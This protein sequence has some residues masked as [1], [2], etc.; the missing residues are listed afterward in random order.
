MKEFYYQRNGRS[1]GP[2]S[3]NE[4]VNKKLTKGTYIWYDGLDSWVPIESVSFFAK[5]YKIN[6]ES[7]WRVVGKTIALTVIVLLLG[8]VLISQYILSDLRAKNELAQ[9]DTSAEFNMYLEKF[10]RDLKV[11]GI[12][13]VIPNQ[14]IIKFANLDKYKGTAYYNGISYGYKD[15]TK[16]EIHINPTFWEGATKAQRYW[17]MYHELCHD[18]LNLD[19]VPDVL[20]NRGKLMYPHMDCLR[21]THM[22]DFIEAYQETFREFSIREHN[23][24]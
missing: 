9:N 7:W 16:I 17:L 8:S 18:L 4:I 19:H 2:Y 11:Y 12:R 20:E 13:P 24:K 1:E 15:D 22:D 6:Q 5:Y 3:Y 21:I 10:Y 23:T 14:V